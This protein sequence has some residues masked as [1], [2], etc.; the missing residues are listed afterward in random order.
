MEN[1]VRVSPSIVGAASALVGLGAGY[2]L[3]P[4]K[5]TLERLLMQS[6][7]KFEK[8]F[9]TKILKDASVAEKEALS[10]IKKASRDYFESGQVIKKEQIIPN[11]KLWHKMVSQVAVPEDVL[12]DLKLKKKAVLDVVESSNFKALRSNL[13]SKQ[14]QLDV[15][16]KDTNLLLEVQDAAQKLADAQLKVEPAGKSYRKSRDA[17]RL[18]RE[19]AM[20][21]LPDKG[22]AISAQW[23]KVRKA[24]S[25]RANVMYE[26]LA[27]LSK[28]E[29]LN[30]DYKLIKKYIPKA[31]T[32]SALTGG[33]VAGLAGVLVGVYSVNKKHS[34]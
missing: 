29:S 15:N 24:I 27:S 4:Q 22:K 31:R 17:F 34:T 25:Q 8:V 21:Q 5:Y 10:N 30:Q 26:K 16:P 28:S 11:A 23:D 7:D 1:S 14:G 9:S 13:S 3:A 20:L 18:A 32:V 12:D 19:E 33:L 6:E 2:A